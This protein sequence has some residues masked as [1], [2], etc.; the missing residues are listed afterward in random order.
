MKKS[1]KVT[2]MTKQDWAT[3]GT[4]YEVK[5]D[6]GDTGFYTV[7]DEDPPEYFVVGKTSD[8]EANPKKDKKGNPYF[9]FYVPKAEEA[10]SGSVLPAK[11]GAVLSHDELKFRAKIEAVS[12]ASAYTKDLVVAGKISTD[13]FADTATKYIQFMQQMIDKV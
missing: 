1:G 7:K 4:V 2:E 11:S 6:N 12:F 5:F 13:D 10:K 9:N 8:Y 3:K